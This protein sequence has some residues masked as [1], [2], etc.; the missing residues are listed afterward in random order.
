MKT[1]FY[2]FDQNNSGGCF[3]TD[4]KAGVCET[5]IIE[6]QNSKKAFKK[7]EEIGEKVPGMFDYCECCGERWSDWVSEKDGK[8][9][10]MIYGEPLDLVKKGIF[11][12][13]C[14]VHYI[15]GKVK[16]FKFK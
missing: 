11:R 10:P 7:L 15:D 8:K 6:A 14:F 16:Q 13:K 1:K 3:V 4:L 5:I 12:N 2:T 9:E